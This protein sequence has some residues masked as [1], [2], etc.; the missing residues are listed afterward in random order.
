M[1]ALFAW[2]TDQRTLPV[3]SSLEVTMETRPHHV[4]AT[5]FMI[6][7][8]VLSLVSGAFTFTTGSRLIINNERTGS[9]QQAL[10]QSHVNRIQ[11][12]ANSGLFIMDEKNKGASDDSSPSSDVENNSNAQNFQ[13]YLGPYVVAA[14][15]SLLATVAFV[16]FVLLDY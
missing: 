15:C 6:L 8:I 7:A 5:N 3:A 16:K 13:S 4:Y 12:T 9:A 14:I 10:G 1:V 2:S 11:R